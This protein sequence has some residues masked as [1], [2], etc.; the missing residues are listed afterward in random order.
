MGWTA[1]F[2]C[3]AVGTG[4]EIYG[5]VADVAAGDRGCITCHGAREVPEAL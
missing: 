2:D 1:V 5:G 3:G 4:D